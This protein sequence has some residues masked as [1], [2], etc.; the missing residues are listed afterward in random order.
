M[1]QR[2]YVHQAQVPGH[3][4]ETKVMGDFLV[5]LILLRRKKLFG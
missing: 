2:T 1:H 5:R 4:F 3:V